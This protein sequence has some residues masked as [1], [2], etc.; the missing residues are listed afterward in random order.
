MYEMTREL[1]EQV[2]K[3]HSNYTILMIAVLYPLIKKGVLTEDELK[4]SFSKFDGLLED[5]GKEQFG[6]PDVLAAS[7]DMIL[8]T[9]FTPADE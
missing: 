1:A 8:R 4:E 3:T 2:G 6:N 7:R 9:L 5:M